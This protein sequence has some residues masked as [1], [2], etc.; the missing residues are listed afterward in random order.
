MS[1]SV[2]ACRLQFHSNLSQTNFFLAQS[3]TSLRL[4]VPTLSLVPASTFIRTST[5]PFQTAES[6][7]SHPLKRTRKM[8]LSSA[9]AQEQVGAASSEHKGS[10]RTLSSY[11]VDQPR[12][13][14]NHNFGNSTHQQVRQ[15]A[16][17]T[18]GR[19]EK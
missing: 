10:K 16:E 5:K 17:L 1:R 4:H 3:P 7:G 14:P 2:T 15:A 8:V 9:N 12:L 13:P 11:W 6:A 19:E 18:H